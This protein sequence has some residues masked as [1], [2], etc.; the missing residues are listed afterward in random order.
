M[1]DNVLALLLLACLGLF[2]QESV[3]LEESVDEEPA[4]FDVFSVS[5][6]PT[7]ITRGMLGLYGEAHVKDRFVATLGLGMTFTDRLMNDDD[8]VKRYGKDPNDNDNIYFP[9]V[10]FRESQKGI[11]VDI[12]A[13]YILFAHNGKLKGVYVSTGVRSRKYN[14]ETNYKPYGSSKPAKLFNMD[15]YMIEPNIKVGVQG[16]LSSFGDE[17]PFCLNLYL[18]I[19]RSFLSAN[20]FNA[21]D[22]DNPYP[23][24]SKM[25]AFV[26]FLGLSV[27][28]VFNREVD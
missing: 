1:R 12:E 10:G 15:Y 13:K 5:L 11:F 25:T 3:E 14:A 4:M 28:Y 18:G 23:I 7:I 22:D 21:K 6:N 26:P 27:G 24:Q 8:Y 9:E 19:G 16:N 2:A 20:G 17:L